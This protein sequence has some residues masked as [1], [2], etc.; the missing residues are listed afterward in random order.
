LF[1]VHSQQELKAQVERLTEAQQK[2]L[3][4]N[5]VYEQKAKEDFT[6]QS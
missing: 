2:I 6:T 5:V 4:E 3:E 1:A